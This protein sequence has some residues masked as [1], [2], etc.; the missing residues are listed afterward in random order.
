MDIIIEK[1]RCL[2]CTL[3]K[4]IINDKKADVD[5]FGVTFSDGS[6]MKG[7]C[8]KRF[9]SGLPTQAVLDKYGINLEEYREVCERLEE[10]LEVYNCGYCS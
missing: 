2:P 6:A 9:K 7:T 4:F 5:D 8:S 1:L 3:G 10:N